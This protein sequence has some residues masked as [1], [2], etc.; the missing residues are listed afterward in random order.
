MSAGAC[1]CVWPISLRVT[2]MKLLLSNL[3]TTVRPSR[4]R[5]LSMF[6]DPLPAFATTVAG[7]TRTTEK[8]LRYVLIIGVLI[9]YVLKHIPVF[10]L[11]PAPRQTTVSLPILAMSLSASADKSFRGT[12]RFSCWLGRSAPPSQQATP[13]SLSRPNSP[14]LLPCA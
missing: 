5:P 8:S 14:R 13:S 9:C 4:G 11:H 1:L 7:Q 6:R 10:R 12:S 2:P 3:S